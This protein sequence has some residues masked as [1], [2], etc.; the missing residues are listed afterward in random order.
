[1]SQLLDDYLKSDQTN[2]LTDEELD[3]QLFDAP[4]PAPR[5]AA[6]PA[7]PAPASATQ[8][9]AS[10]EELFGN[11]FA[12]V[13]DQQAHAE[14]IDTA[15]KTASHGVKVLAPLMLAVGRWIDPSAAPEQ[16]EK[17]MG[18]VLSRLRHDAASVVSAYGVKVDE[19]PNWLVSQVSGQL[20]EV[21]IGAIERNNG[22][23]MQG[24]D[25]RYLSPLINM[26]KQVGDISSSPYA[27]PNDPQWSLINTLMIAASDV[28]AE[29][30]NFPYFH[31]DPAAVS[32]YVTEFLNERVIEGTLADLT[33]RWNLSDAERGHIG[34][35]LI[36]Q[37]GRIL[38][39]AWAEN[40]IPTLEL[41]KELPK[42]T[43]REAMV[44][45]Y[46]LTAVFE[47]FENTYQGLE[48]SAVGALRA[49]APMREKK[50]SPSSASSPVYG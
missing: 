9:E 45:G 16:I 24:N 32:Q 43:R 31:E 40:V 12:A 8:P 38:A 14:S 20:M 13:A 47:S 7:A 26:A 2:P 29:Y 37:A 21:L 34:A 42:E 3:R 6:Q 18:A 50:L 17:T 46:P 35:S 28:M 36:R 15:V 5:K 30:Q 41:I 49:M 44:G 22:T 10:V 23:V 11:A 48:V 19:A 27:Y 39:N 1:V 4:R 25:Q 33:A